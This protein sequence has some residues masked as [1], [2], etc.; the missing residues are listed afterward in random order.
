MSEPARELRFVVTGVPIPQ[1]SLKS[2]AGRRR[3]GTLY[4]V[5]THDNPNTKGWRLLI[6]SAASRALGQAANRGIYFTG[7]VEFD[8]TFYLPRPQKFL[9]RKYAGN[10]TPHLTAPDLSK[11]LRAAEDALTQ[12]VWSDDSQVTDLHGRK[13]YCPVGEHPR[14]EILVRGALLP[15]VAPLFDEATG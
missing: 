10:T 8:V 4:A 13:R 11:L 6:A 1:G 12:V 15:I 3:D 5:T 2:F 9:T 14:A 7:A